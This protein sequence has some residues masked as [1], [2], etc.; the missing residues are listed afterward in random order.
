MGII[1]GVKKNKL[2]VVITVIDFKKAFDSIHRG[3]MIHILKA[4][5]IPPHH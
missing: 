3:K 5:D 4:Y 2:P 1:V